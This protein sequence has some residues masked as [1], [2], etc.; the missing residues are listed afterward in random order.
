MSI[1]MH[2]KLFGLFLSLHSRLSYGVKICHFASMDPFYEHTECQP[3]F[4][5]H[6]G[7]GNLLDQKYLNTRDHSWDF[8]LPDLIQYC[9]LSKL[10]IMDRT[11]LLANEAVTLNLPKRKLAEYLERIQSSN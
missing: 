9:L 5:H 3:H 1:A 8:L 4:M 6:F 7:H 11:H 2:F 10:S